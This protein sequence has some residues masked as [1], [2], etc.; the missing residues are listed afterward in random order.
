VLGI[1]KE[2]GATC[3][4][5]DRGAAGI[6]AKIMVKSRKDFL[7]FDRSVIGFSAI[8][9]RGSNDLSVGHASPGKECR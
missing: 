8:A 6:N 5:V 3:K 9:S 4:I 1:N 2:T 7:E